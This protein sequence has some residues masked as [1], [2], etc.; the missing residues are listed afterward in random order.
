[1]SDWVSRNFFKSSALLFVFITGTQAITATTGHYTYTISATSMSVA[2]NDV[3]L[4]CTPTINGVAIVAGDEIA[5]MDSAG[6]CI[7]SAKWTGSTI[8]IPVM[9][10][11]GAVSP[12]VPG[13]T[14]GKKLTFHIW[15]SL[16]A[17]EVTVVGAQFYPPGSPAPTADST[18]VV[19]GIA[20]LD[21]LKGFSTPAAPALSAPTTASVNQPIA[22]T[23]SWGTLSTATS[24][25]LQVSTV[26]TFASTVF[27][28]AGITGNSQKVSGLNNSAK[29][30]WRA[31]ATNMK[32]PG[33]W[34]SVWNFTTIIDTPAVPVLSLPSNNAVNQ[35]A[36]LTLAWGTV[37][38]AVSY[39][40]QVSTGSA[41]GSTVVSQAGLT[42][43]KKAV[44]GL[45]TGTGYYWQ[46]NATNVGGTSAWSTDWSFTTIAIPAA[47]VT[48]A[49]SA[50]AIDQRTSLTLSWGSTAGAASYAVQLSTVSTFATT[51]VSQSALTVT[52]RVT[53]G[54]AYNTGYYWRANATNA[55]GT[56][57]WSDTAAFTTIVA[58]PGAV[59]LSAPTTSSVNQPTA[60][61]L[62]WNSVA[63]AASY[64]L[65]VATASSFASTV[66]SQTGLTAT[67]KA[68][69]G[70]NWSTKL[71]W[72]VSATDT[73]GTGTWSSVWN[74]TTIIDTPGVPV[75]SSPST[76]ANNLRTA[77]T[78]SWSSMTG[79]T[80][81]NLRI[82]TSSAFGSTVVS[83]SGLTTA[84]RALSGLANS[85]SFFWEVSA[86][87]LGGTSSWSGVWSFTTIIATPGTPVL[88]SPTN[89][90]SGMPT[91][92][93]LTWGTV[94]GAST[95]AV[96]LS[97]VSTFATTVANQPGLTTV[98]PTLSGLAAGV[99]YF[100]RVSGTNAG[101]ISAW[102]STWSFT[103]ANGGIIIGFAQ[104]PTL[105]QGLSFFKPAVALEH[106]ELVYSIFQPCPVGIT[107]TD[108]KGRTKVL[109]DEVAS[110]G[111][112]S[113]M[114]KSCVPVSGL[115]IVRFKAQ[116]VNRIMK[117]MLRDR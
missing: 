16:T 35:P 93:T 6:T 8:S 2:C 104:E 73:G 48:S 60:L 108:L 99:R 78:F 105:N 61:T 117:V 112:Y 116:D 20:V 7:G 47:P 53:T 80:S 103:V 106:N 72:R 109:V 39:A 102:S 69:S 15:D 97:T 79:A 95:Y 101:G 5:A 38:G 71:F 40:V 92:L 3:G 45:A 18:Y 84:S 67:T 33:T 36:S 85:A 49:P 100:W 111:R 87:N 37:T 42:T 64:G 66:I 26:S 23:L 91:A 58:I 32:A 57:P 19:N 82:A 107:V 83:Q 63:N 88:S 4:P 25:G 114:L 46:V 43:A 28:Q 30:F 44:P 113:I 94:T 74:F 75:L 89:G 10:Y 17:T 115:Y 41:F 90:S 81:Y 50:G 31:S 62:S 29:Y 14:T 76:G 13:L 51:V 12:A 52:S 77:L 24:Y 98:T 59:T 55:G 21:S 22:I 9:G 86:T 65:Q 96:Q 68:V 34:S 11:D 27:G 70:L 110:P 56:S 1:M 54:L